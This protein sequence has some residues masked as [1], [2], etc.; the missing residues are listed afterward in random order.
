MTWYVTSKTEY[1]GSPQ[2]TGPGLQGDHRPPLPAMALVRVV[3][4]VEDC[5]KVE[6]EATAVI[7]SKGCRAPRERG[8]A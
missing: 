4:L 1:L 7:P 5:A 2:G 6:I 8:A 3:A